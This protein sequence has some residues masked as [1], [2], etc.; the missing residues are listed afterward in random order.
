MSAGAAG[1]VSAGA[2]DGA[3]LGLDAGTRRIG[4]ALA[5]AGSTLAIPLTVVERS[6]D[7]PGALALL[8]VDHE[9][10]GVVIG[11]PLSLDG[12]EGTAAAAAREFARVVGERLGLPVYLVDE[13]LS[14]VSAGRALRSAGAGGRASR[15]VIDRSAAAVILQSYL[16]RIAA[17]GGSPP[18]DHREAAG[19]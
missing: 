19:G 15:A 11:L 6:E 1:G 7:W 5:P 12:S 18:S 17:Q 10:V 14:T 16:D 9:A 8:A 13:R 2:A 3:L 4:V